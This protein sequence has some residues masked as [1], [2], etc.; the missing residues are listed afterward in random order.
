MQVRVTDD[1]RTEL[2][3]STDS[4]AWLFERLAVAIQDAFGGTWVAQLDGLDQRYWDLR[5]EDAVVTLHSEHYLGIS[6]FPSAASPD[7]QA[8]ARLVRRIA[9]FL[10]TYDPA[11]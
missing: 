7:A 1:A 8:A 5:L 10:A 11:V 9:R 6:L 4:S 2:A 3:I